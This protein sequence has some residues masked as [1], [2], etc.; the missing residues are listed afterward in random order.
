[1]LW[2][3]LVGLSVL[4]F[5]VNGLFHRVLMRDEKSDPYVQTVVFYTLVG[6]FAFIIAVF[7]GGFHYQF[8]IWQL[9]YFLLLTLF[10][11]A[12]PV[13]AFK[14]IKLIEASESTI[15]FSSQK[16]WTV[17]GA[18]IF[19]HEDFSVKK[20]LGTLIIL[21]GIIIAQWK[22]SKFVINMGVVF[23]LLSALSYAISEIISFQILR[24]FD[25]VSFTVYVTLL[26]VTALLLI[27]PKL[28]Q[29]LSFYLQPKYALNISIVSVNDTLATL[30]VFFAY[31]VG[32]NA[33]QIAPIMSTQ[34]ILS[35]LLAIIFLKERN[36]MTN[37]I[38]GALIVVV[39][40]IMVL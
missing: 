18:F 2:L 38:I 33:A 28:I 24:N 27:K 11:T 20:L 29:K 39:G 21:S 6:F 16:L 7:R 13:F 17:I 22:K 26:P 23:A 4:L 15:L 36:N 25:A 34:T 31:Q 32:R 14:A 30:F 8:S 35:V 19:L 3:L 10:A 40:V 12:A 5:S 1:M 37:K 9:P